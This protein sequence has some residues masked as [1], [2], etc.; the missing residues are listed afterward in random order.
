MRPRGVSRIE[1]GSE[2]GGTLRAGGYIRTVASSFEPLHEVI[3]ASLSDTWRDSPSL[4]WS[5]LVMHRRGDLDHRRRAL[6]FPIG[7][8]P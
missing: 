7:A 2:K 6:R 1:I 4:I 3:P 8:V 5:A